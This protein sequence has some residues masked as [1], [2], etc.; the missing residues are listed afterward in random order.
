MDQA[1]ASPTPL[2]K[3]LDVAVGA[4]L[5]L[6]FL[7]LAFTGSG[8]A[9]IGAFAYLASAGGLGV[10]SFFTLKILPSP[11]R[12]A[13]VAAL[14]GLMATEVFAATELWLV[15]PT[16]WQGV[17]VLIVPAWLF[18][19]VG[20]FT[21]MR[22]VRT[23]RWVASLVQVSFTSLSAALFG[24]LAFRAEDGLGA[25]GYATAAALGAGAAG[26]IAIGVLGRISQE[27]RARAH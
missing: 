17:G 4:L 27:R 26:L 7:T 9:R 11:S 15:D 19:A 23:L 6:C 5:A 20:W 12:L 22:S 18:A 3:K 16:E 2:R 25:L 24:V 10:A 21:H 13:A 8:T 1:A 14:G